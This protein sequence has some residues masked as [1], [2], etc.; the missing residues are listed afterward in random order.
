MPLFELHDSQIEADN[1]D[2][3]LDKALVVKKEIE[4]DLKGFVTRI[5]DD[6]ERRDF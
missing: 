2:Q 6:T 5:D 3:A 1:I 4:N